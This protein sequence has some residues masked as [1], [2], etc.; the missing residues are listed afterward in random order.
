MSDW[1]RAA[2]AAL[3]I[4]AR[5]GWPT[6]PL[7]VRF[8]TDENGL[9]D[10]QILPLARYAHLR[11]VRA[12]ALTFSGL[13]DRHRDAPGVGLFTGALVEIESDTPKGEEVLHKLGLPRT[14]TFRSRRGTKL[15]LRAPSFR[16]RTGPGLIGSGRDVEVLRG[17]LLVVPPTPGY[18][19]LPACSPA[20]T[21]LAPLPEG[22]CRRLKVPD[23]SSRRRTAAASPG[24][25]VAYAATVV[26]RELRR[27]ASCTA[28]RN[29][30]LYWSLRRVARLMPSSVDPAIADVFVQ[31]AVSTG[32]RERDA[33]AT[34]GSA[35]RSEGVMP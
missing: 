5:Y 13:W 18:A 9:P 23:E 28:E 16:I 1:G 15:L 27:V 32:L 4:S 12:D 14:W 31:A 8:L 2:Q 33:R 10:K 29:N 26:E 21:E 30:T 34:A 22:L 19:F 35:L 3:W 24:P 17:K 25:R 7:V 6:V 11:D 20:D